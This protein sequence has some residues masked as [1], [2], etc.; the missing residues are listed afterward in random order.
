MLAIRCCDQF[1][2]VQAKQTMLFSAT[3]IVENAKMLEGLL[4]Q[5]VHSYE[6]KCSTAT[7]TKLKQ[8]YVLVYGQRKLLRA[9]S[10]SFW[11]VST[12]SQPCINPSRA[13]W[14]KNPP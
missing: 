8:D 4:R 12:G 2:G 9:T 10:T 7:V 3:T 11:T 13:A 1:T 5:P 6:A 14:Q